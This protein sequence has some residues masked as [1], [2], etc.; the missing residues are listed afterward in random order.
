[1][2]IM[3]HLPSAS[4]GRV[5][6]VGLQFYYRME[7]LE[8]M[9]RA[10]IRHLESSYTLCIVYKFSIVWSTHLFLFFIYK[11]FSS[12]FSSLFSVF[13]NKSYKCCQWFMW[14]NIWSFTCD[15]LYSLLNLSMN[16]IIHLSN[17]SVVRSGSV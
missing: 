5:V 2:L 17:S 6:H 13:L 3:N 1:M 4:R 15:L 10:E 8:D 12:D 9:L 14:L 16:F 11:N 7:E